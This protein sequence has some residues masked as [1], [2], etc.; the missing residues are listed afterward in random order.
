M[1]KAYLQHGRILKSAQHRSEEMALKGAAFSHISRIQ[2]KASSHAGSFFILQ[3]WASSGGANSA[4]FASTESIPQGQV[5]PW[6][7]H[8]EQ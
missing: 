7:S 6:L 3:Q 1:A 2:P 4:S 5:V 8:S